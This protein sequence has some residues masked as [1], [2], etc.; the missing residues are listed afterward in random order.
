MKKT[1]MTLMLVTGLAFGSVTANAQSNADERIS[2][3]D[4]TP[5]VRPSSGGIEITVQGESSSTFYI[6]SITGQ[7]VK[8]VDISG[9]TFIDLPRGCYI[10]KC[11]SWSKKV[12]VR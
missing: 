10:I 4:N 9:N 1:F 11:A 12:V 7:M 8:S 2:A 5:S 6:Y 3:I